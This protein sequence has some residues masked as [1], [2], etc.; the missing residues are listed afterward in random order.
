MARTKQT[1]H[2]STGGKAPGKQLAMKAA[3]KSA[4][5]TGVGDLNQDFSRYVLSFY[6][7]QNQLIKVFKIAYPKIKV[8]LVETIECS[9]YLVSIFSNF[10][11]F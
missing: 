9:L 8:Y 7:N 4:P 3:H 6:T 5:T 11:L 1:A 2:K 10:N